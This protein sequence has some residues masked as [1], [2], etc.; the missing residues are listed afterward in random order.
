MREQGIINIKSKNDKKK[1]IRKAAVLLNYLFN[2]L[3][4]QSRQI[5]EYL[6]FIV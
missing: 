5:C 6:S 1:I 3:V 4:I 2:C